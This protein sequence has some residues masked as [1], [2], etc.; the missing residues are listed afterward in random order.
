MNDLILVKR[1][2]LYNKWDVN[3]LNKYGQT[4]LI[5]AWI[6][7]DS[8][9]GDERIV[10]FLLDNGGHDGNYRDAKHNYSTMLQ[11]EARENK[12]LLV[13]SLLT[14]GSDIKTVDRD[15]NTAI[16]YALESGNSQFV[17]FL[18]YVL[19]TKVRNCDEM[20]KLMNFDALNKKCVEKGY[21]DML[22]FFNVLRS[23]LKEGRLK[24][25]RN[26]IADSRRK[27]DKIFEKYMDLKR[28]SK[29]NALLLKYLDSGSK[30]GILNAVFKL[31]EL[32][33]PIDDSILM[34][35]F[36]HLTARMNRDGSSINNNKHGKGR[37]EALMR[38]ARDRA[39]KLDK[40]VNLLK[41]TV[42]SALADTTNETRKRDYL[43]FQ[44]YL[45]NSNI[46][47]VKYNDTLLFDEICKVLN[48]EMIMQQKYLKR[49]FIE[50]FMLKS[51]NEYW[52]K[53]I[54]FKDFIV[55]L[56]GGNARVNKNDGQKKDKS[57]GSF[58]N[59]KQNRLRQDRVE[60]GLTADVEKTDLF[61]SQETGFDGTESYDLNVYLTNLLILSHAVNN[62][63]QA[64]MKSIFSDKKYGIQRG[65]FQPAPV[66][67][68]ARCQ[69]KAQTGIILCLKYARLLRAIFN[70]K[71]LFFVVVFSM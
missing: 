9:K 59:E 57:L 13:K 16:Y 60:N 8:H 46:W 64:Q 29:E 22:H 35:C 47:F 58:E 17:K 45:L 48:G 27:R 23:S 3:Q 55:E 50:Q 7:D 71:F 39:F 34:L 32:K 70:F 21:N 28:Q 12:T 31:L 38:D 25:V 24:M 14:N 54:S 37:N 4:P 42:Q 19:T 30:D 2:V 43:W 33:L 11:L 52:T 56:S 62:E 63:F 66:K 5:I 51:D 61:V 65:N 68:A 36:N 20:L 41:Q 15:N 69:I 26:V 1:L 18:C 10:R 6:N 49:C 53:L 44:N 40:L 67:K